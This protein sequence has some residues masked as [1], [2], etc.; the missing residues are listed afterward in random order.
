MEEAAGFRY[1]RVGQSLTKLIKSRADFGGAIVGVVAVVENWQC[2]AGSKLTRTWF[3]RWCPLV[4]VR[5][6]RRKAVGW[7]SSKRD[8][9]KGE[10]GEGLLTLSKKPSVLTCLVR[11]KFVATAQ[12]GWLFR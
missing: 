9:M 1:I 12:V 10:E 8:G 4:L 11:S 6:Y 5:K 3:K 2:A 7:S